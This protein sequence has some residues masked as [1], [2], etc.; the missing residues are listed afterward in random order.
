MNDGHWIM[1]EGLPDSTIFD[2]LPV[3][4]R[5]WNEQEVKGTLHLQNTNADGKVQVL[6]SY[7]SSP[8][9]NTVRNETFYL[10]QEQLI[11]YQFK[12]AKCVLIPPPKDPN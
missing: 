12:G 8:F 6:V 4:V 3:L 10:S 5:M 7:N 1:P 11:E 9:Q 2:G